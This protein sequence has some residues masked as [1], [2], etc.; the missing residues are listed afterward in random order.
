M[1]AAAQ[2]FDRAKNVDNPA[3]NPPTDTVTDRIN[4][5]FSFSETHEWTDRNTLDLAW[6]S[7]MQGCVSLRRGRG[8]D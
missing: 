3:D 8:Q 1:I 2:K 5:A 4:T 6:N 7:Q